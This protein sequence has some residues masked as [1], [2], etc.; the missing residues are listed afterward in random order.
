MHSE[1]HLIRTALESSGS[2]VQAAQ[3]L[4]ISPRTLRYKLARLRDANLALA[5]NP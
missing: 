3:K 5:L 4:G 2:R 1:Q